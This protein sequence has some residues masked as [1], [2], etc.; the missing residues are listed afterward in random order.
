M[1]ISSSKVV[2]DHKYLIYGRAMSKF[3]NG[4]QLHNFPAPSVGVICFRD[5]TYHAAVNTTSVVES[6]NKLLNIVTY[7]EERT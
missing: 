4:Y 1:I 3:E 7:P 5:Q 2:I 6:Q